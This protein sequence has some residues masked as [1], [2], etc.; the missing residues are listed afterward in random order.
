MDEDSIYP[1]S[2]F[3]VS[4]DNFDN[5]HNGACIRVLNQLTS[6]SN[7]LL[8]NILMIW[9]DSSGDIVSGDAGNDEL[10]KHYLNIIFSKSL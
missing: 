7:P 5:I 9:G 8:N 10:N 6:Q 1:V 2:F 3:D 4:K